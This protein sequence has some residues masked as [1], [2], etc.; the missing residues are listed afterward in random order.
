MQRRANLIQRMA[1]VQLPSPAAIA[2]YQSHPAKNLTELE[3]ALSMQLLPKIL[4]ERKVTPESGSYWLND[5]QQHRRR[6]LLRNLINFN[7]KSKIQKAVEIMYVLDENKMLG[8][9]I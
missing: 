3:S 4:D 6:L 7:D 2:A 5:L 8:I 1:K 9:I